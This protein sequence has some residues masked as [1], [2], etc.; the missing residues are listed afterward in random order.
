MGNLQKS[1]KMAPN[2]AGTEPETEK[3]A[4]KDDDEEKYYYYQQQH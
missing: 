2:R 4:S 1:V 3:R